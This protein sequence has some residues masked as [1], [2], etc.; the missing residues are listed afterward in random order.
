L[1]G[2]IYMNRLYEVSAIQPRN[3]ILVEDKEVDVAIRLYKG[4]F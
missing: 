4:S 3:K 2:E 1:P